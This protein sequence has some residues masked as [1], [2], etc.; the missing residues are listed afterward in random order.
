MDL[1]VV[2]P[3]LNGRE[4]LSAA[5]DALGERAPD[6]EVIVVNGPS[7]DGTSGMVRAHSAPDVLLELSERNINTARNAGIAAATGDVVTFVSHD[8]R[9]SEAWTDVVA[10]AI[11][12]GADAVTGPVHRRVDGGHTTESLETRS[13][14]SRTVRYF[15]GGNVAFTRATIEALD[16]FDQYLHTGAARDAAHRLA[17]LDARISW[18][19]DMVVLREESDDVF[20]RIGDDDVT[21]V[22]GLKYRSLAYRLAKNYGFGPSFV[23]SVV[24]D[25]LEEALSEAWKVMRGDTPPSQW[26]A[27]GRTVLTN[28]AQ[29]TQDG[30]SARVRD[31]SPTRNPNGVSA[32]SQRP[33]ARYSL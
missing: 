8:S 15:D 31:R 14:G 5:L 20:H 3:T 30:L 13:I 11:A 26:F 17:G 24:R 29:G 23:R 32:Q 18:A 12:D 10:G 28:L 6:A 25:P 33:V 7:S 27:S 2:V 21:T 16:G 1:S 9:I 4:R 19:A 22:L